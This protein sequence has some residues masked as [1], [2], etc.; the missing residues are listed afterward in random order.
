[1]RFARDGIVGEKNI[2]MGRQVLEEANVFKYQGS[3][4]TT[5]RLVEADVQ[6]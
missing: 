1:M 2:M 3:L 5:E 6:Q 4:V